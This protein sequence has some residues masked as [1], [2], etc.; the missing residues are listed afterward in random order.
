MFFLEHFNI[1]KKDCKT[2]LINGV[3]IPIYAILK[4]IF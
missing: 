4:M 2:T 1:L 3:E